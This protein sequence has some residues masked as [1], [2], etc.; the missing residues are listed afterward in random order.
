MYFRGVA[1]GDDA[2]NS[3][4]VVYK[5]SSA[6]IIRPRGRMLDGSASGTRGALSHVLPTQSARCVLE[7]RILDFLHY[8]IEIDLLFDTFEVARQR[9]VGC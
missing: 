7:A 2:R 9:R 1:R 5:I 8:A 6:F 4:N 3:N